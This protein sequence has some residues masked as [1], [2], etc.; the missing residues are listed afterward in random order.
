MKTVSIEVAQGFGKAIEA[1][2][3]RRQ[4]KQIV[5]GRATNVTETACDVERDGAPTLYGARLNAI[6]DSLESFVTIYPAANS[7]VICGIVENLKTEAIVLRCSE[8]E[9]V[10]LKIAE[11]E[12]TIDAAGCTYNN[13]GENLYTVLSDFIAEVAKIIVIQGTSPN[14]AALTEIKTRLNKILK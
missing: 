8:V 9:K 2:A 3:D 14:V 13:K 7:F 12:M 5:S 6:D 10:K 11:Y 4:I 1:I